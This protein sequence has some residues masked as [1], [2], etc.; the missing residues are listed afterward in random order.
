MN[1]VFDTSSTNKEF[2]GTKYSINT[3]PNPSLHQVSAQPKKRAKTERNTDAEKV[4]AKTT[5]DLV[6]EHMSEMLKA[7][8]QARNQSLKLSMVAYGKDL[9][10]ELLK[11]AVEVERLFK[12]LQEAVNADDEKKMIKTL[13][14]AQ[15]KQVEGEKA[16]ARTHL[17]T[18]ILTYIHL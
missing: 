10:D 14:K 8:A 13:K 7:S 3:K 18:Y 16:K 15:E 9:S 12:Q 17:H 5:K 6:E 1:V 4:E 2:I 11:Y